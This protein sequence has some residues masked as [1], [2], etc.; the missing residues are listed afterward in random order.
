M[1]PDDGRVIPT[2]IRQA[3]EGE[4]LT[5]YG[6]GS[7]TRSFCYVDDLI[8]GLR[9]LGQIKK[10][11]GDVVNIGSTNEITITSLAEIVSDMADTSVDI[12]HEP[13]PED[14]PQRRQPDIGKAR[15]LLDWEPTVDLESGL[16]RTINYFVT[17]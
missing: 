4:D 9:A 7:Q 5:V 16:E 12:V 14:D 1:R 13:L 8:R 11:S 15:R 10:L 17:E 3:L 6:D 2:F